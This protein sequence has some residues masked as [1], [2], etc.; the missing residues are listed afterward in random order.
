MP[1]RTTA[2]GCRIDRRSVQGTDYGL[3][4]PKL[5]VGIR[6][7]PRCMCRGKE[8]RICVFVPDKMY[9][10]NT[11]APQYDLKSIPMTIGK[12]IEKSPALKS[13]I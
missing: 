12:L 5:R 2:S 10:S 9:D 11:G 6:C 4:S 1:N 3:D 7:S 8:K 13:A